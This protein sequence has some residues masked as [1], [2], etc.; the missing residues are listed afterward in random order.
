MPGAQIETKPDH[1]LDESFGCPHGGSKT[2]VVPGHP[3]FVEGKKDPWDHAIIWLIPEL[4]LILA[5][6][7]RDQGDP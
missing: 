2:E 1:V 5:K 7:E 4:S 6:L 3:S